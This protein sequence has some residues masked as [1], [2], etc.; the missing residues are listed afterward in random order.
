MS[1]SAKMFGFLPVMN[2][3]ITF[4]DWCKLKGIVCAANYGS[5]YNIV[6]V[7][8]NEETQTASLAKVFDTNIIAGSGLNIYDYLPFIYDRKIQRC[9][10]IVQNADYKWYIINSSVD[11]EGVAIHTPIGLTEFY[12]IGG[13][14]V[15][16][17]YLATETASTRAFYY[18]TNR[19]YMYILL[20]LTNGGYYKHKWVKVALSSGAQTLINEEIYD[21]EHY[22][23]WPEDVETNDE[24]EAE[25]ILENPL[26]YDEL[27]GT[28]D[29]FPE[30][31]HLNF[32]TK[33]TRDT[34]IGKWAG[35]VL[36]PSGKVVFVPY[37]SSYVG[38][39]DPESDE[40][41]AKKRLP[42]Y[43]KRESKWVTGVLTASGKVVFVPWGSRYVG[44]YDPESNTFNTCDMGASINARFG[45]GVLAPSGRVIF[46]PAKHPNIGIYDPSLNTY[47]E[48][49][50]G[51]VGWQGGVLTTSGKV[52]FVPRNTQLIGIYD[53]VSDSFATND[54]GVTDGGPYGSDSM[55]NWIGG[56]L[57]QSGKVVFVPYSSRYIG[58]Y[59][60]DTD[61]F[62]TKDTEDTTL[63][64]WVGGVLLST[65]EIL[66]VPYNVGYVGIYNEEEDTFVIK[67]TNNAAYSK[68]YYGVVLPSNKIVLVPYSSRYI[69]IID[70]T[71]ELFTSSLKTDFIYNSPNKSELNRIFVST[72]QIEAP[73]PPL[74]ETAYYLNT[75]DKTNIISATGYKT[76]DG[77]TTYYQ[78]I[79]YT[80]M[81]VVRVGLS[82]YQSVNENQNRYSDWHDPLP[83]ISVGG[84]TYLLVAKNARNG[85]GEE[86]HT[87]GFLNIDTRAFISTGRT[88][89]DSTPHIYVAPDNSYAL[90]A[91]DTSNPIML[92]SNGDFS[93]T[94]YNDLI[95]IDTI[96]RK[97]T[98]MCTYLMDPSIPPAIT[99]YSPASP[100]IYAIDWE[101]YGNMPIFA[102]YKIYAS[103]SEGYYIYDGNIGKLMLTG[104][105]EDDEPGDFYIPSFDGYAGKAWVKW[106]TVDD[107]LGSSALFEAPLIQ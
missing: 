71:K 62:R 40:F 23:G 2:G 93:N 11:D 44:I 1:I 35:G 79:D 53:P 50:L 45:G 33:D 54:T 16:Y 95:T 104:F 29:D 37:Y 48:K 46:V 84:Q 49:P 6:S 90:L 96:E 86:T 4:E 91:P 89:Y 56:V 78:D 83:F 87:L 80:L 68:W 81:E 38:V 67:N 65:G 17:D 41:I 7:E 59:D 52:I 106:Y 14:Y 19:K 36:T 70:P 42:V 100:K 103:L 82:R 5:D 34:L 64:K 69:G 66:F 27:T 9:Y 57:S 30:A 47:A 21:S 77:E 32:T 107:M 88:V 73:V 10:S 75:F 28:P 102:N 99:D 39:Y 31:L 8:L 13:A 60:P 92:F 26:Y 63:S 72:R 12:S 43:F 55:G 97:K 25:E 3:R 24:T 101:T 20:K 15:Y 105:D 61:S 94:S 22:T 76:I 51:L 18:S 98:L 58:I 74:K 85:E